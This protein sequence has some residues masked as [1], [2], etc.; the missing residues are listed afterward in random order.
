MI[1]SAGVKPEAAG[2]DEVGAELD[3]LLGVDGRERRDVLRFG[4]GRR[5]VAPVIG[6]DDPVAGAEAEQDLG[7]RPA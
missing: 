6:R 2:H 1:A 4:G 7:R 5:V 3:D